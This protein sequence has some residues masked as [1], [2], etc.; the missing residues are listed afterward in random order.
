MN[1]K[2]RASLI[3]ALAHCS[4]RELPELDNGEDVWIKA[5]ALVEKTDGC[6]Y[7]VDIHKDATTLTNKVKCDF[8]PTGA[9]VKFKEF[10]PYLYLSSDFMPTFND[11]TKD[12]RVKYLERMSPNRVWSKLSLKELNDAV[13]GVAI[14]LQLNNIKSNTTYITI[15]D[16]QGGIDKEIGGDEGKVEVDM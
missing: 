14:S 11:K 12:S 2:T 4:L 3:K 6:D 5:I 7:F 8:G 1:S 15:D 13:I 10:R 9:I 16:E